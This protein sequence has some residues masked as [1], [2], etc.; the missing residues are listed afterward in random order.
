MSQG[1]LEMMEGGGKCWSI[2]GDHDLR[3]YLDLVS[4]MINAAGEFPFDIRRG[5]H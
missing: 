2:D 3:C 4:Y 5:A 1:G